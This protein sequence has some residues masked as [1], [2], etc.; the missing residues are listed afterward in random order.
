MKHTK[1]F[2]I[3]FVAVGSMSVNAQ[4]ASR[5][6]SQDDRFVTAAENTVNGVVSVKSYAT[7]RMQ[8]QQDFG[9]MFDDPFFEYFFGTPN[10]Q[11]QRRQQQQEKPRQQQIGLGSG[12][13]IDADGYIVTNNHVIADAE[14][15][16]VTLNDNRNYAAT[17]VGSD[18]LTDL[19][20]IKI[21]APADMH[22]I[23]M[24]DSDSL[25]VGQWVLAVGNPFGFTSSVTS[26]IVSAKA[27]NISTATGQG[28]GGI[29]SYIQTDAAVNRGNSG[30]AL[31]NLDGEL[32]G[33]NTAIYSQNGSY[34][35]C[36]FAIPTSIVNKVVGDIRNYGAVQRAIL[37]IVIRELTPEFIREKKLEGVTAGIYVNEVTERSAARQAGILAGDVIVSVGGVA[38]R[39]TAEFQ[40][41]V[42]R[43]SP[44]DNV[45]LMFVRDGK[46][47][48]CVVTMKNSRGDTALTRAD[49]VTSL[50]CVFAA[51]DDKQLEKLGISHGVE[52]K[53]VGEGRFKDA[54]VRDG[55]VL[56][57]VNGRKITKPEDVE[58][59]YKSIMSGD[60]D[61][62]MYLKGIYPDGKQAF[63]AVALND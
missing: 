53:N 28:S 7:P 27:R 55:F 30:G 16:E 18:P 42:A 49:S 32:V 62:V 24:G 47:M 45:Q 10:R 46:L 13:I 54:G 48:E 29:E 39:N 25:H 21:D 44:G 51:L 5:S 43:Y 35:G 60:D 20:V 56:M 61:K 15:L 23:P 26:G 6:I 3:T 17:V 59:L 37:G 41:M 19:A 38:T 36:S 11:Q 12:V 63:Y 14:R 9:G 52:V 22:V 34:V 33:I 58:T 4:T 31:V 2:I 1:A 57:A 50:G 40:E 8:Q